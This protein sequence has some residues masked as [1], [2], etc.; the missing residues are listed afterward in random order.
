MKPEIAADAPIIGTS[1]PA[2]ASKMRGRAG[3][4]RHGE[5][6]EKAQRAE[7]ARDRRA[8]GEQ[9]HAVEPEMRPVA[10]DATRR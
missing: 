10:V 3:G 7:A 5:E 8:E 9:P 4:S 2:C 6:R 1:A